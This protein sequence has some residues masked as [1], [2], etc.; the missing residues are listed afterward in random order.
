M[1]IFW[2]AMMAKKAKMMTQ[3]DLRLICIVC[4]GTERSEKEETRTSLRRK[5]R[6]PTRKQIGRILSL[7][8]D[9]FELD[10]FA[11]FRFL[12]LSSS[13]SA[14]AG[15]IIAERSS[16]TPFKSIA[17]IY[18][19]LLNFY[20][21]SRCGQ[22]LRMM[23]AGTLLPYRPG[24]E[25][26]Y[27]VHKEYNKEQRRLKALFKIKRPSEGIPKPLRAD[28]LVVC[29][30]NDAGQAIP[31]KPFQSIVHMKKVL[32]LLYSTWNHRKKIRALPVGTLLPW[33]HKKKK[34]KRQAPEEKEEKEGKD[35]KEEKEGKDEKEEKV[36]PEA[37]YD[38]HEYYNRIK[39]TLARQYGFEVY[40]LPAAPPAPL[41]A[42]APP[43]IPPAAAVPKHKAKS[44][45]KQKKKSNKSQKSKFNISKKS[46]RSSDKKSH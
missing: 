27:D 45:S 33:K 9:K 7:V 1:G 43:P 32:L 29:Q 46:L 18:K 3:A 17:H 38:A 37:K 35:E 42:P 25:A 28:Q 34:R 23:P 24:G 2:G 19:T 16:R 22:S 14:A 10:S 41:P 20:Q 31:A 15:R 8:L 5:S 12:S 30:L 6:F 36:D 21:N 26:K 4:V 11:S 40:P 13:M 39:T 44:K